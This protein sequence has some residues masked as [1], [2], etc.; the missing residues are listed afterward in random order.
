M[1]RNRRA[2]ALLVSLAACWSTSRPSTTNPPPNSGID[3]STSAGTSKPTVG[4]VEAGAQLL[5]Q[6]CRRDDDLE[7]TVMNRTN[8]PLWA[9]VAPPA[10]PIGSL[11]RA[12]AVATMSDG[13][14]LLRKLQLQPIGG[15]AVFTGAVL[16]APGESDNG[17]VP[18]GAR[19][20]PNAPN[21]VGAF[22]KGTTI[23]AG[24]ALEVGYAEQR[25]SDQNDAVPKANGLVILTSFERSRQQFARS[26]DLSWR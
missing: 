13:N 14:L 9:F 26:P 2:A 18:I 21:F 1:L 15:E 24:V 22:S 7:W 3:A 8:A 10:G 5:V 4:C 6:I 16:L 19:L 23:I 11:D 25:R 12:N 17:L 20:N